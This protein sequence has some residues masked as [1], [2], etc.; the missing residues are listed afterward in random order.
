MC[1]YKQSEATRSVGIWIDKQTM[2]SWIWNNGT[3]CW[4]VVGHLPPLLCSSQ[5]RRGPCSGRWS[6]VCRLL[7]GTLALA[8]QLTGDAKLP[9]TACKPGLSRA[10]SW[11]GTS[12][13]AS[14]CAQPGRAAWSRALAAPEAATIP[15]ER[16]GARL[17]GRLSIPRHTWSAFC[18]PVL[19]SQHKKARRFQR[20]RRGG[21]VRS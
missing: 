2:I 18:T 9:T 8:G 13:A 14:V 10:W 19:T 16:L 6:T 4:V 15:E 1:R 5:R 11:L 12:T 17:N 21:E 3:V 7:C 20:Q